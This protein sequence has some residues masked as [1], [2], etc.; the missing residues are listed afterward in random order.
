LASVRRNPPLRPV[1]V[2]IR[3][4]GSMTAIYTKQ[5]RTQGEERSIFYEGVRG[6][7]GIV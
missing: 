6:G 2:N 4:I 5:L 1:R 7:E 3:M